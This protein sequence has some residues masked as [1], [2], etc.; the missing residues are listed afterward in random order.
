MISALNR[1]TA[2]LSAVAILAACPVGQAAEADQ[3]A[4]MFDS[5]FLHQKSG[6]GGVDLSVFAFSNRT[7][8]GR[9]SVMIQLNR[10][11]FGMRDVE[12]AAVEGMED[13]QPCLPVALL[14]EMGVK[15]DAFPA[16]QGAGAAGCTGALK[17][18]PSAEARYDQDKNIL[19]VSIA[20]AALDRK[21]RGSVS[22]DLWDH[23]TTAFWSS[24]RL[25]HNASRFSSGHGS[26]SS[27]TFASFRNGFNLGA[28]RLRANG[29]YYESSGRSNWDWSDLYAERD[30]AAWR[31]WLRAGDSSTP[32]NIFNAT[33]FR[34]VILQSDEGM[35]PDSQRGFAPVVRG[36]APSNAKVTVRQNGY[37]IY[38]TFVPAGPFV[39]DDLYSTPGGGD[40]E[41]IIEELG[42][43]TTRFYQPFSALPTMLREGTW[44]YSFALGQHRQSYVD[45]RPMMAQLTLAH[46]LPL[47]M[48]AYGGLTGAQGGY[49]AG[50][51]GLALNLRELGAISTDVTTSH[52]RDAQGKKQVGA[53]ARIQYAKAFPSLG[54]DLTLAGYRYN[55]D[56]YR[57]LDDAV[58]ERSRNDTYRGY[59]RMHEYQLWLSQRVGKTSSLSF[60]YYGIAY[61]NAPRNATFAQFS[62]SSAIG[63]VG[64][65][66]NYGV[67][68]SP[69]QKRQSTAM[70]TLSIP[71][72]GT[73]NAS[74]TMSRTQ[75]QG[76]SQDVNLS[77]ALTDDY[78]LTYAVQGGVTH[79]SPAGGNGGRG[80]ASMS[81]ASP[82]GL[83]NL[84]HGYNAGASN[85]NIDFSGAV[86]MDGKGVLLGQNIGETA[87]IVEAPGAAGVEVESYPGVRTNSSGRALV[88]S[89]TPYR[90]NRISL[91]PDFDD[92]NATL[93]QNVAT[94][95]PTRGAIVVAKF[96]TELGRT[97]L[98]VLKNAAGTELPFGAAIY[99]PDGKQRGIVGPVGRA[100][101]TGLQGMN[102]FTVKWGG[103]LEQHCAFEIDASTVGSDAEGTSME[104]TCA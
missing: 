46:G 61:R 55:S 84:S 93:G 29:S 11:A 49:Y 95:V 103:A 2:G 23:G 33:R 99:E 26:N 19:E 67:N 41:V 44:N 25:S 10:Q 43:R 83:A 78:S 8:P 59:E 85:T 104:L 18:L 102:H 72:G 57:S 89:A 58:R 76:V 7:L 73:H 22:P 3:D 101:L 32:G 27:N 16:L 40:L 45:E 65:A 54:T 4:A 80:Y 28:W 42:G 56:G 66:L 20:Q 53:A 24:Y 98:V 12:F 37:A 90:E 1:M 48:T 100:W 69:W 47:G 39:I 6:A 82:V 68:T 63:P 62:F 88:P 70:L 50:A 36:V 5:S 14:K 17:A 38:T 31:G 71:L 96:E 64:Y 21:A 52:S 30:I 79:G 51:A 34:G 74:Y 91:K 13:A 75:G 77:G 92:T 97:V 94:V 35:L 9:K 86:V 87:V 60:N 15:T 81:Y